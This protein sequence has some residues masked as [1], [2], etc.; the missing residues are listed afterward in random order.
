MLQD[1]LLKVKQV[2]V[3]EKNHIRF[4]DWSANEVRSSPPRVAGDSRGEATFREAR[5]KS[6]EGDWVHGW[7]GKKRIQLRAVRGRAVLQVPARGDRRR[8]S[9]RS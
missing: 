2:L 9:P 6:G 8:N 4:A 1:A 5:G 7:L 3:E